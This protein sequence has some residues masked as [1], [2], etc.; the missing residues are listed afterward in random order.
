MKNV[1]WGLVGLVVVAGLIGSH[2]GHKSGGSSGSGGH[3]I[4]IASRSSCWAAP[5]QALMFFQVVFSNKT[6]SEQKVT[7]TP[8]A[9]Y[10]DGGT[11]S[12]FNVYELK[13]PAGRFAGNAYVASLRFD[14][15]AQGHLPVRCG[16]MYDAGNGFSDEVPVSLSAF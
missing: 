10:S 6:G 16:V 9:H 15:N 1:F 5:S 13:I 2:S 8:Q 3:A 14:Y 4:L 11:S 12:G 7:V